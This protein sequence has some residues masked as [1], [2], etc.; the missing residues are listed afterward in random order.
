MHEPL[1]DRTAVAELA[2]FNVT[3]GSRSPF[4]DNEILLDEL[5]ETRGSQ[6]GLKCII[7]SLLRAVEAGT[8]EMNKVGLLLSGG[9]DSR[10][11]LAALRNL[12]KD[13]VTFC[14][15][16]PNP[17]TETGIAEEL[18]AAAGYQ[19][20]QLNPLDIG[21]YELRRFITPYV[22]QSRGLLSTTRLRTAAAA[23]LA[24]KEVD[25]LIWGEGEMI[26]PPVIPGEYLTEAA[27][28]LLGRD[29]G[30]DTSQMT[31]FFSKSLPWDA[32]VSEFRKHTGSLLGFP[33]F[34]KF[35]LWLKYFSYPHV[36]GLLAKAASDHVK[37][38]MPFLSTG[39]S[40]ALLLRKNSM[41]FRKSWRQSLPHMIADR[42]LY[43]DV[44]KALAPEFLKVRTDR[45]YRLSHDGSPVSGMFVVAGVVRSLLKRDKGRRKQDVVFRDLVADELSKLL[46]S[47]LA[48]NEQV[49]GILEKSSEWTSG[50]FHELSQLL[51]VLTFAKGRDAVDG[52]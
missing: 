23:S 7:E 37:V 10:C 22:M 39:L 19:L 16:L 28:R 14:W 9:Y 38:V 41:A 27:L 25:G 3:F 8:S 31:G 24:S 36:Y 26:R 18:A 51:A 1:F 46:P 32:A 5:S 20:I 45:G 2:L 12:G 33:E 50:Q 40:D 42:K 6:A 21:S 44:I 17:R 35:A 29:A 49:Y 4:G 11:F 52:N 43:H 30:V 47:P 48:D 13:V 34:K 15:D